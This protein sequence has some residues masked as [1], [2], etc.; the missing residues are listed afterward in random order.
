MFSPPSEISPDE[1]DLRESFGTALQKAGREG[2]ATKAL[3][4]AKRLRGGT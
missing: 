2:E 3:A 1:P 4:A